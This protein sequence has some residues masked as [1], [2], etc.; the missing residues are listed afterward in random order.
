MDDAPDFEVDGN[1]GYDFAEVD[2]WA[3]AAVEYIHLLQDELAGTAG[4]MWSHGWRADDAKVHRG[5]ELREILG[6]RGTGE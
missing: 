6:I 1:M 4:F 2:F 5:V 3:Q